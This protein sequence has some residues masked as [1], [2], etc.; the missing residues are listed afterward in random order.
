MR[1]SVG[2][3]VAVSLVLVLALAGDGLAA[4]PDPTAQ[5]QSKKVNAASIFVKKLF[6]GEASELKNEDFDLD[7]FVLE[8]ESQFEDRWTAAENSDNCD[9][10]FGLDISVSDGTVNFV[11]LGELIAWIEGRVGDIVYLVLDGVDDTEKNSVN[12]G[13]E[14]LRAAGQKAFSLLKAEAQN[15]QKPND[16]KRN[17]ARE[18]A[19][20]K[21][22]STYE[23]R[24]QKAQGKGVDVTDF[25]DDADSNGTWDI[26]EQMEAE[27][28]LLVEDILT[29]FTAQ[30]ST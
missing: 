4:K 6:Y 10:P 26:L 5:C 30:P 19:M 14:L 15:L 21:F 23:K 3:F 18:R 7:A 17:R 16:A 9:F 29:V 11:N 25:T 28:D 13:A 27:I 20:N 12:L 24:V 1:K 8:A 22:G 2:I